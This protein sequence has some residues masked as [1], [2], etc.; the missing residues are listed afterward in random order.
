MTPAAVGTK[1][2]VMDIV[3][4]MTVATAP[5]ELC[6]HFQVL[7]VACFA[8]DRLVSAIKNE[9]SLGVV[10]EAPSGPVDRRVAHAAVIRE[11]AVV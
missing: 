4:R 5:A 11:T 2:S 8:T 10:V 3:A 7:P 1:L 9:S 6:L